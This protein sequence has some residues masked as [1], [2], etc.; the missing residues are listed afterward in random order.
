MPRE[1]TPANQASRDP[2]DRLL[3]PPHRVMFSDQR[4]S[5]S[6]R[7]PPAGGPGVDQ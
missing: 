3:D 6:H 4:H 1:A 5:V 7:S 2:G